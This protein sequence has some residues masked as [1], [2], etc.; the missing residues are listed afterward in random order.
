MTDTIPLDQL[1]ANAPNGDDG[2]RRDRWGRLLVVPPGG[3]K[4]EGY[5]RVTTIAKTTDE[6]GGLMPWKAT[7]AVC[8][9]LRRRGIRAQWEALINATGDPWYAGE[10]AKAKCKRLVEEAAEAGGA[11]DRREIGVALHAITAHVDRGL[12]PQHLSPETMRDLA[13]YTDALITNGIFIDIHMIETTVV[14]DSYKVGGSFDRLVRVRGH[15]K[16]MVADLKTG[17]DIS[18][19]DSSFAVQIAGYAHGE[20]IYQQGATPADDVR[21]PMPDVDQHE[22]LVIW[23]PAGEGRCELFTVDLDTGWEGFELS[24]AV[25]AWRK[26]KPMAKFSQWAP[27]PVAP[28]TTTAPAPIAP[29]TLRLLDEPEPIH[30]ANI[31]VAAATSDVSQI[32]V[33]RWTHAGQERTSIATVVD[34]RA[35]LQTRINEV[36]RFSPEARA[37]LGR[38]WPEGMPTLAS[39]DSHTTD[40]L[41][42]IEHCLD[43]V[44]GR[45][46]MPFAIAR[47]GQIQRRED[48]V[49][50]RLHA[51]F[52]NSTEEKET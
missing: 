6:G 44:E 7:M 29:P 21:L 41:Y 5:S 14:L 28:V 18:Y 2:L 16:L 37:D 3:D 23:L 45:H 46:M 4:A 13:A 31:H 26:R 50:G 38:S 34:I 20:A 19:S 25:R 8:G 12:D 24:M 43:G 35:W 48:S 11:T 47:P 9:T 49:I 30:V 15:D 36:G 52:P 33:H 40:Q 1:G 42:A 39:T 22:G 51:T 32:I 10:E 27:A 17:A